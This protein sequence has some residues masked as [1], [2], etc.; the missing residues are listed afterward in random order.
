MS[1]GIKGTRNWLAPELL[2]LISQ[3]QQ[4]EQPRSTV[5][6]DV[7]AMGLVFAYLLLDGQHLYVYG[8]D[9]FK[10]PTNILDDDPVNEEENMNS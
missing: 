10:I 2:K 6:S 1:S 5:K 3:F 9:D 8:S 4:S 7:F